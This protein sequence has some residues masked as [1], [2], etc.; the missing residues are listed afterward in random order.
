MFRLNWNINPLDPWGAQL[1]PVKKDKKE[2]HNNNKEPEGIENVQIFKDRSKWLTNVHIS[3][4][5]LT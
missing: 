3:N 5:L 4:Y 1:K 2:E